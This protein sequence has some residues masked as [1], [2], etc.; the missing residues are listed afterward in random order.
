MGLQQ[1]PRNGWTLPHKPRTHGAPSGWRDHCFSQQFEAMCKF[2][3]WI[4][5]SI[6]LQQMSREMSG[7]G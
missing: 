6:S 1:G 2:N 4:Y 5:D 7:Q 3:L